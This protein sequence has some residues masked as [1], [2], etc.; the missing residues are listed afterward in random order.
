M[1][2]FCTPI[3]FLTFNRFDT[4]CHV[5]R[6]IKKL[7][8]TKLYLASDGPRSGNLEDIDK[9]EKIRNY[10]VTN[11]DWKCDVNFLFR[12]VNLGCKIAVSS[13]ISWF[14]QHEEE[15]IILEDDCLPDISFFKYCSVLLDKYRYNNMIAIISGD[16]RATLNLNLIDDYTFCK[17][18]LIWGWATWKRVWDQYDVNIAKWPELKGKILNRISH[19]ADTRR[20]WRK[21][22]NLV[23]DNKIDTW[24]YQLVFLLILNNSYCITPKYNLIKNIGFGDDATHTKVLDSFSSNIDLASISNNLIH[25]PRIVLDSFVCDYFDLFVF[26][27]FSLLTRIINKI[28][29]YANCI[30]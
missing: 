21:N 15:G 30:C 24:D 25:P 28:K 16:G 13:A 20:F 8:P 26:K 14:F 22:F 6:E 4:T 18:P 11:I 17:Y 9:I 19:N 10:L 1:P 2:N 3:L 23:Y 7:K 12:D 29:K 5:F 27:E